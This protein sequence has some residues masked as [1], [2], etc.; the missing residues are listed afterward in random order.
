MGYANVKGNRMNAL[1][2]LGDLEKMAQ[3]VVGSKLFGVETVEQA[4][5]LMLLCQAENV[6]PMIAL[7]DYHIVEGKP[8]LKADAMLARFQA[9]GGK[10][11]W[12]VYTDTKVSAYFSHPASPKPVLIE[13][14]L[15]S[16]AKVQVYNRKKGGWEAMTN[17][18]TWK[19]YPRQ[20]LKARVISEGVRATNPGV[21]VGIYT[22]EET[23]DFTEPRTEKNITPSADV[24]QQLTRDETMRVQEVAANMHEW[25]AQG[26]IGD[27]VYE[28]ENAA[29]NAEQ[30]IY[31]WTHF[32]SKQRSAMKKEQARMRAAA[33]QI[34]APKD[35]ASQEEVARDTTKVQSRTKALEAPADAA[36]RNEPDTISDAARKR[37]EARITE[38]KL[39]R[40]GVKK[41]VKDNF[42]HDH[43]AEMTK[44]EYE[45]L[46]KLIE[47][48]AAK[49]ELAQHSEDV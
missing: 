1:V 27:A 44:D 38:L 39:D 4:M 21:A 31:L 30:Q 40:E 34:A 12:E 26:S 6:H 29:L 16:A 7:R 22:V 11:E 28:M 9:G 20:M 23:Q 43:F 35:A 32:D 25:L 47:I 42:G 8:A 19:S 33:K 13:W 24:E 49:A 2:P 14:S 37:L 5:T 17:K 41:Y 46:D 18:H 48:R 3:V 45:K 36:P 10:V 15:E